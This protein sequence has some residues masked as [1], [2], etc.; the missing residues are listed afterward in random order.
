MLSN[1]EQQPKISNN[2]SFIKAFIS[3]NMLKV[4]GELLTKELQ[5]KVVQHNGGSDGHFASQ[6]NRLQTNWYD[7]KCLDT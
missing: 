1:S 7:F 4:F 6:C 2:N 3:P 5:R